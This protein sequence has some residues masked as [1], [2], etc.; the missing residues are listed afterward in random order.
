ML[1]GIE[2][3][4][5]RLNAWPSRLSRANSEGTL[6]ELSPPIEHENLSGSSDEGEELIGHVKP[7]EM[8]HNIQ[9]TSENSKLLLQAVKDGPIEVLE[10]FLSKSDTNLEETDEQGRTPLILAA[11]LRKPHI[12][13][14]L[15][16]SQS[17]KINA[18]DKLGRTALHYCVQ[19]KMNETIELLFDHGADANIQDRGSFPPMYYAIRDDKYDI[20][21]LLLDHHATTDF[22]FPAKPIPSSIKNLI[23]KYNTKK[24]MDPVSES[25]TVEPIRA[26]TNSHNGPTRRGRRSSSL[27]LWKSTER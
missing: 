12:V 7:P 18:T 11:N 1:E 19:M 16:A 8:P 27:R 17:I 6:V 26:R 21:K 23:E 4:K 25:S 9:Q 13:N 20:V 5:S 15:L 2:V 22:T 10:S 14:K 24:R 3:I